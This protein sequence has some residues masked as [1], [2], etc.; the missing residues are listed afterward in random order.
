LDKKK[1]EVNPARNLKADSLD[2]LNIAK[3]TAN[4]NQENIT[5]Y[6]LESDQRG[7]SENISSLTSDYLSTERRAFRFKNSTPVKDQLHTATSDR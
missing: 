3:A 6:L 7:V 4:A 1:A 5:L 2:R